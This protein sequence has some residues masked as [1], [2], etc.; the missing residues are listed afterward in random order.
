MSSRAIRAKPHGRAPMVSSALVGFSFIAPFTQIML[1]VAPQTVHAAEA[2]V[3]EEIVVT[4]RRRE[5]NLLDVPASVSAFSTAQLEQRGTQDIIE[6][7]QLVPNVTLEV[8]RSSN[9]TL[10]PFIRGIGQQDPIAGFEQGVGIYIDDIYLNRPQGAVLQVYEVDRV[11]VLRGPQGTLYGRNTIGGAIKYVTRRIGDRP[12]TRVTLRGG[13]YGQADV[14][15]SVDLPLTST[16][17]VGG[18]VASFQ[19]DGFGDNLTLGGRQNYNKDILAARAAVEWEPTPTLFVRL[20]GDYSDDESDPRQ[21]HRQTVGN[22]SGAPILDDVFDTRAGLDGPTELETHGVAL[23]AE[24]SATDRIVLKWISSFRDD[25]TISQNDFD[26]LP[27]PDL[28]VPSVI[29]NEQ[30]SQEL[31]F[32]YAGDRLRGVVGAFFMNA[33]AFNKFDLILGTTVIPGAFPEGITSFSSGE[34]GTKTWSIF[35][36]FSY[37]LGESLEVSLGGRFTDDQRDGRILLQTYSGQGSPN[38]GGGRHPG[39][40]VYGFRRGGELLGVHSPSKP[41]VEADSRS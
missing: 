8:S 23:S 2:P 19:R 4:A 36:D 15:T 24:W 13:T 27:A 6:L 5:E 33:T 39:C 30:F 26:S 28:D 38:M 3:I 11:E 9:T 17:R 16:L 14:V 21:G 41:H 22:D 20:T 29:Q 40:Y 32:Q 31:Q 10:T 1:T 37:S 18:T 35:S 12:G 34:F 25:D 7:S